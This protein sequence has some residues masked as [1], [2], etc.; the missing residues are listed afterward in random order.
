MS[1]RSHGEQRH[2]RF[3]VWSRAAFI[4][5]YRDISRRMWSWKPFKVRFDKPSS[6]IAYGSLRIRQT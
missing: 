1:V 2:D 3:L 5:S 4:A 6:N